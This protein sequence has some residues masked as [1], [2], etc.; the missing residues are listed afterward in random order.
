LAVVLELD[1]ETLNRVFYAAHSGHS[2]ARLAVFEQQMRILAQ[3]VAP[4]RALRGKPTIADAILDRI[5]PK[6]HRIELK[7]KSRRENLNQLP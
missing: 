5:I 6:A 7:G 2:S 4:D 3:R 1:D